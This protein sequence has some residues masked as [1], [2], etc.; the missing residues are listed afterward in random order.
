MKNFL[1]TY[2]NAM[3]INKFFISFGLRSFTHPS[4]STPIPP[5]DSLRKFVVYWVLSIHLAVNKSWLNLSLVRSDRLW[6]KS[7]PPWFV[8]GLHFVVALAP[9]KIFTKWTQDQG[10]DNAWLIYLDVCLVVIYF[11]YGKGIKFCRYCI[12]I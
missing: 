3:V 7:K 9:P 10:V 8:L 5:G 1:P 12:N 11:V 4:Q 6:G 2:R